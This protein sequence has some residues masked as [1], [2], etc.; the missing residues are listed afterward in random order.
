MQRPPEI[1]ALKV[2]G[3]PSHRIAREGRAMSLSSRPVFV[4]SVKRSSPISDGVV[5]ISV[6]CGKG[7]YIR[8]LY[9]DIG[10]ALGCGAHM[11]AL[12][13]LAVGEFRAET[14]VTL[15]RIRFLAGENRLSEVIDETYI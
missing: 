14:A 11:A 5:R 8:T 1:S 10:S 7:T 13:R 3:K 4:V 15:G 12:T 2:E 9:A 6:E